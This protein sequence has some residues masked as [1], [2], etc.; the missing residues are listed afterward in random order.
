M[1]AA[2]F[3]PKPTSLLSRSTMR[4]SP[5]CVNTLLPTLSTGLLLKATLAN[6]PLVAMPWTYVYLLGYNTY[7]M[8]T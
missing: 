4:C 6:S 8:L 3:L 2:K 5:I 1:F 7:R